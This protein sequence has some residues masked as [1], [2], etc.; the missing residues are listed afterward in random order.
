MA[1]IRKNMKNSDITKEEVMIYFQDL[2]SKKWARDSKWGPEG[3]IEFLSQGNNIC[4][5]SKT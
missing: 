4:C 1:I 3:W 5:V 2:C